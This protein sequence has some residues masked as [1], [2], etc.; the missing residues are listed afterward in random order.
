[1]LIHFMYLSINMSL[2]YSLRNDIKHF[3]TWLYQLW[4]TLL[5]KLNSQLH[6]NCLKS[7]YFYD[8]IRLIW[9]MNISNYVKIFIIMIFT[10][11]QRSSLNKKMSYLFKKTWIFTT[12]TTFL[13]TNNFFLLLCI[14]FVLKVWNIS[15]NF[16]QF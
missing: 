5:L 11:L 15:K 2:R 1:M 4:I 14:L 16:L 3:F 13:M 6:L 12:K 8:N 9:Q 7:N 10:I